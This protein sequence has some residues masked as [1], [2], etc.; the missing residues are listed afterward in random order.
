MRKEQRQCGEKYKELAEKHG[1][2]TKLGRGYKKLEDRANDLADRYEYK[3]SA[4]LWEADLKSES[5]ATKSM[6]EQQTE[7]YNILIAENKLFAE[8]NR[9]KNSNKIDESGCAQ[10]YTEFANRLEKVA[11]EIGK[12]EK[13][14]TYTKT[15]DVL[16]EVVKELEK[17]GEKGKS[18]VKELEKPDERFNFYNYGVYID[19]S[20]TAAKRCRENAEI[21][22]KV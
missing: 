8:I 21:L 3:S 16:G 19:T 10:K 1:P 2:G 15:A 6:A 4:L 14:E 9:N 20:K 18:L 22:R 17:S 7:M 11:E 12:L 13:M 5:V